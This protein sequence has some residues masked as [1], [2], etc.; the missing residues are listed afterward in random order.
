MNKQEIIDRVKSLECSVNNLDRS[1]DFEKMGNNMTLHR[2]EDRLKYLEDGL[3]RLQDKVE[4]I[5][6]DLENRMSQNDSS[7]DVKWLSCKE[8]MEILEENN[9]KLNYSD[10]QAENIYLKKVIQE[11]KQLS[12]D[13]V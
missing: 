3:H 12:G 9:K 1:M 13:T 7:I 8:Y 5:E 4:D 6:I 2:T 11:I 10:I